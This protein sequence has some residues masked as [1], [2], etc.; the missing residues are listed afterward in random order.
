[1]RITVSDKGTYVSP[2]MSIL[3]MAEESIIC[4]SNDYKET[5]DVDGDNDLGEI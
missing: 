2:E 3:S 5:P 4:S 1:M